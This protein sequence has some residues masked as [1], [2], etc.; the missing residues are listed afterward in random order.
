MNVVDFYNK[1]KE[2]GNKVTAEFMLGR[3]AYP[4]PREVNGEVEW[5]FARPVLMKDMVKIE[6]YHSAMLKEEKMETDVLAN[7]TLGEEEKARQLAEIETRKMGICVEFLHLLLSREHPS[8]TRE[9]VEN[10]ADART[11]LYGELYRIA[12]GLHDLPDFS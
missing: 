10:F 3:G 11:L 9:D 4:I 5:L 6:G 12:R 8:L 1:T 7:E 2:N